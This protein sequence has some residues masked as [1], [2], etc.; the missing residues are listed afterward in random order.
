ML[1]ELISSL[2][3]IADPATNVDVAH[4]RALQQEG[5]VLIDVR[6]P[7]EYR[8]GH[9]RGARNIPLS[10]LR[11]RTGEI[12]TN[13]TVLVICQSGHR[14][15]SALAMLQREQIADVRNVLG[16]TSA[17]RRAGLPMQ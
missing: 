3:G 8:A 12:R 4:A 13:K 16:G 6:E 17:W 1:R 10:Q 5:A 2:I 11:N 15:Q 14:S 9:A 7:I